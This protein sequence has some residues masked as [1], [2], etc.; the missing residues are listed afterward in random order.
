MLFNK[1]ISYRNIYCN[2]FYE[3][4]ENRLFPQKYFKPKN[5]LYKYSKDNGNKK[6][7]LTKV[8]DTVHFKYLLDK[9]NNY[10]IYSNYV[11]LTN[12]S[13]HSIEKFENLIR[14]FSLEKLVNEK[15]KLEKI[16]HNNIKYYK[17]YD[18]CHRLSI[19]K[20][21]DVK[22]NNDYFEIVN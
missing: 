13:D 5:T 8:V 22:L 20:F 6:F 2:L 17:V 4:D 10:E 11:K 12:Q 19:L 16:K 1:K 18:G 21:N 9:D 14:N 7:I 15:I 3:I